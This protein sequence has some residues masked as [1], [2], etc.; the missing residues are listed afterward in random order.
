M[1]GAP[2][3]CPGCPCVNPLLAL[4]GVRARQS[5]GLT[6]SR[7]WSCERTS[8]RRSECCPRSSRSPCPRRPPRRPASRPTTPCAWWKAGAARRGVSTTSWGGVRR[9][10]GGSLASI[11]VRWG[12]SA[13]LI[14]GGGAGRGGGSMGGGAG[15]GGGSYTDYA[16]G[17]SMETA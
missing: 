17:S 2:D 7:W 14:T 13:G 9:Q 11:L 6:T 5:G 15:E 4:C 10:T 3:K 16:S 8:R 12:A 1:W